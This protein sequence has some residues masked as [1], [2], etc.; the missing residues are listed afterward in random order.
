MGKGFTNSET[1]VPE[2]VV[3]AAVPGG[4]GLGVS[5]LGPSD[6]K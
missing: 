3:D 4:D 2:V 1:L 5:Y 6:K